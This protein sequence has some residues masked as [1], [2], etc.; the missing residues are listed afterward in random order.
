MRLGRRSRFAVARGL[1][2]F[3]GL[4]TRHLG[5]AGY[6][7]AGPVDMPT[8]DAWAADLVWPLCGA[9][10]AP[11]YGPRSRTVALG[12]GCRPADG[13]VSAGVQCRRR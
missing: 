9:S 1:Q 6:K 2:G 10:S 4:P 7:T 5:S 11:G 13:L 8:G 3:G 12:A